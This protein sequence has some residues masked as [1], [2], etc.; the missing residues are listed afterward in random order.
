MYKKYYYNILG[1]IT[2]RLTEMNKVQLVIDNLSESN[3]DYL[4]DSGHVAH[5]R[6]FATVQIKL[7]HTVLV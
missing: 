5:H 2:V 4:C 3:K 1:E 7:V 6:L